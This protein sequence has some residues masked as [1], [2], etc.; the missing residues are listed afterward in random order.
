MLLM[1]D[2]CEIRERNSKIVS[3][4]L[5]NDKF[6]NILPIYAQEVYLNYL[7]E[8]LEKK[9]EELEVLAVL[10]IL[11]LEDHSDEFV[12]SNMADVSIDFSYPST[13]YLG[14]EYRIFD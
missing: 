13:P 6:D 11:Y 12:N 10:L 3:Y 4:L 1:D 2:D 8:F 5:N 7:T 9:F 14:Q